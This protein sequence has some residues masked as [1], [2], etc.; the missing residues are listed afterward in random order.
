[1]T[2]AG[3]VQKARNAVTGVEAERHLGQSEARA[4]G[5][6]AEVLRDGEHE[7]AAEGMAIVAARVT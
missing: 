4:V 5:G 2:S 7:A 6:D 3:D 1:M